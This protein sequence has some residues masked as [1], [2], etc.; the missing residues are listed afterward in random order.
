MKSVIIAAVILCSVTA[1]VIW[2]AVYSGLALGRLAESTEEVS[3]NEGA[4]ATGVEEVEAE[5]RRVKPFLSLFA[6]D[7]EAREIELYIEDI[8]S[9]SFENDEE[10]LTTA[11]SRLILHIK[12]LR[13]LSGF[14]IEAIF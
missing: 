2:A 4:T 9:A 3:I 14:S 12:Q 13:R 5:Y 7:S 6:C 11:K 1:S 8:K 10:A